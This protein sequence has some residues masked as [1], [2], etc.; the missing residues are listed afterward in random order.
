[1]HVNQRSSEGG[2]GRTQCR[3]VAGCVVP[4]RRQGA[5]HGR[6]PPYSLVVLSRFQGAQEC[7]QVPGLRGHPG[8]AA[9]HPLRVRSFSFGSPLSVVLAI[10]P[11]SDLWSPRF[12][13][14]HS[15]SVLSGALCPV[16]FLVPSVPADI[17]LF[18][19][20]TLML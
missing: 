15:R 6:A 13:V 9:L 3:H 7:R 12:F 11:V 17:S 19:H 1:M 5:L 4:I 20:E 16:F 14:H 18:S 10:S 8:Q 2:A